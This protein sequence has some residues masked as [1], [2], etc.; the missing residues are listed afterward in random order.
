[1]DEA[2][3]VITVPVPSKP[4]KGKRAPRT[5]D[6]LKGR[7]VKEAAR[8]IEGAAVKLQSRSKKEIVEFMDALEGPISG[9][10]DGLPHAFLREFSA[11]AAGG[12]SD[13]KLEKVWL[14]LIERAPKG[15]GST[16]KVVAKTAVKA[17]VKVAA[18]PA[19]KAPAKTPTPKPTTKP[20]TTKTKK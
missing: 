2:G 14:E 12:S 9:Y 4:T 7:H 20:P 18:K 11:Y 6:G 8:Q 17:P 19:T 13:K 5:T 3:N 16:D 1:V 15:K 10:A